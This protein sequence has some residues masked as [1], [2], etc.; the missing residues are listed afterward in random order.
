MGGHEVF[1]QHIALAKVPEE[2][3]TQQLMVEAEAYVPYELS[4]VNINY[5]PLESSDSKKNE[6]LLIATSKEMISQ[7]QQD[8]LAANLECESVE[9]A[10]LSLV[11][12]FE[13]NY[14]ILKN[15]N[16]AILEI[17][18]D[19]ASFVGILNGQIYFVKNIDF[20]LSSYDKALSEQLQLSIPEAESL[21]KNF[22]LNKE[23]PEGT[24][25]VVNSLH[26]KLQLELKT[27]IEFIKEVL[28]REVPT[29]LFL[30]GAG[31]ALP[32]LSQRIADII[33]CEVINIFLN[34]QY[35][36]RQIEK[37]GIEEINPVGAV[38][39]GLGSST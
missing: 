38:L 34:M 4:T 30:T 28:S 24:R 20:G 33:P 14:G 31:T 10:A 21:R 35:D 36:E 27:T 32:N 12:G 5:I 39:A 2:Q 22:C 19:R 7:I 13:Y 16:I 23:V 3:W 1:I 37:S 18:E 15:Q 8:C 17:R 11:N 26:N 25:E 6:F 9:S 29:N